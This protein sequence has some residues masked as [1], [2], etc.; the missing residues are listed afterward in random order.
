MFTSFLSKSR[1]L[2]PELYSTISEQ[3]K[4]AATSPRL[5]MVAIVCFSFSQAEPAPIVH[6]AQ[7]LPAKLKL[8]KITR[9]SVV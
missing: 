2:K 5:L 6:T 8:K 9:I 7:G 3:K 1:R 4:D